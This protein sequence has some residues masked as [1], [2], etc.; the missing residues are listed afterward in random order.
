MKSKY[1][2]LFVLSVSLFCALMSGCR[3][4]EVPAQPVVFELNEPEITVPAEGGDIRIG[5]I[6]ENAPE[7]TVPVLEYDE[8]WITDYD[9]STEGLILLTVEENADSVSRSCDALVR[10]ADVERTLKIT[11][12]A[13]EQQGEEP[14]SGLFK[15]T[16]EDV[17]EAS[18]T[19][20]V[21]PEDM[22]STYL[23]MAI[24]KKDWESMGGGEAVFEYVAQEYIS[25]AA[26]WGY[27]LPEFLADMQILSVGNVKNKVIELLVPSSDHILF[28]A[29]MNNAC[30]RTSEISYEEFRTKDVEWKDVGFTIVF[31]GEKI[32]GSMT[33]TP[34]DMEQRYYYN[35]L[36][37]SVIDSYD[38]TLEEEVQEFLIGQIEFFIG[39][40][41]TEE[42]LSELCDRGEQVLSL[43]G[44]VEAE[45]EYCGFAFSVSE[46][47]YINSNMVR[48]YYVTGVPDPSD[49]V[50][51]LD[52]PIKSDTEAS[53][54]T[55]VSNS[56]PYTVVVFPAS[57][58]SGMDEDEI[59]DYILDSGRYDIEI[60]NGATSQEL[61]GLTSGTEYYAVAFG[62]EGMYPTTAATIVP[63]YTTSSSEG[64]ADLSIVVDEVSGTDVY[65]TVTGTPVSAAYFHGLAPA[66]YT[67]QDVID[68]V[69][70]YA[71]ATMGWEVICLIASDNGT[72]STSR[73]FI[74]NTEGGQDYLQ[75]GQSCRVYAFGVNTLDMSYD[76]NVTFS[77]VFTVE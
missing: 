57:D 61:K 54:A 14:G 42:I 22:E 6:E 69:K 9:V 39:Y 73:N 21:E 34:T 63:F 40:M 23:I 26:E 25:T 53:W 45:T 77:E 66:D 29:G 51:R 70:A 76:E 62:V 24:E 15:I 47:G 33:V 67:S 1:Y 55:Q 4:E 46:S 8:D 36:K 31:E 18:V 27:S 20:S 35:L 3:S 17:G 49:N 16:I 41:S 7:G 59:V 5:Y 13:A 68:L 48:K 75:S 50:I 71:D 38:R 60:Y 32:S 2:I 43:D 10:F 12:L 44:K 37:Q 65:Y 56:D 64:F 72:T 28:C 19:V 58:V 52:V 30:E 11:Q 74:Y